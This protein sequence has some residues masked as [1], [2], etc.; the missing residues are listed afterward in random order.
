MIDEEPEI[1]MVEDPNEARPPGEDLETANRNMGDVT[2][3]DPNGTH[4]IE[5]DVAVTPSGVQDTIDED[6]VL[7]Q[8]TDCSSSGK[9]LAWEIEDADAPEG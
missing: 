5:P 1:V 4:D 3:E 6:A 8:N 2:Q 7:V 9:S